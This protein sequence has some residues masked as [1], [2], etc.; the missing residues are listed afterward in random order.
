MAERWKVWEKYRILFVVCIMALF[1]FCGC[2]E[3]REE[4]AMEP[5][6]LIEESESE[7]SVQKCILYEDYTAGYE[8]LGFEDDLSVLV[9]ELS[10]KNTGEERLNV[11]QNYSAEFITQGGKS[12]DTV[13]NQVLDFEPSYLES[14]E[15]GVFSLY[16]EVPREIREELS[17][18]T[19]KI[20]TMEDIY[21]LSS[22]IIVD[23]EGYYEEIMPDLEELA[24]GLE[25]INEFATEYQLDFYDDERKEILYEMADMAKARLVLAEAS[26]EHL[27]QIDEDQ[28]MEE[29]HEFLV[30]IYGNYIECLKSAA[31]MREDVQ[32]AEE[33]GNHLSE[34]GESIE[35]VENYDRLNEI[36]TEILED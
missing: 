6:Q 31:Q 21:R 16:C 25:K 27:K 23:E 7:F 33:L 14:G 2:S 19:V 22:V 29:I 24:G 32:N 12:Y 4:I 20:Y 8:V 17:A 34:L 30:E 35:K 10:I 1:L 13:Q 3:K 18:L 9:L 36:M 28:R 26:Y 11:K 5:E 15:E